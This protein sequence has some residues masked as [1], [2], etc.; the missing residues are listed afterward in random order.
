MRITGELFLQFIMDWQHEQREPWDEAFLAHE[1]TKVIMTKGVN[2]ASSSPSPGPSQPRPNPLLNTDNI[3]ERTVAEL[4]EVEILDAIE[5]EIAEEPDDSGDEDYQ[6]PQQPGKKK[7]LKGKGRAR[8]SDSEE[9]EEVFGPILDES[10][11]VVGAPTATITDESAEA[12]GAPTATIVD[13]SAEAVGATKKVA[14]VDYMTDADAMMESYWGTVDDEVEEPHELE[15]D[16]DDVD[17]I[18]VSSLPDTLPWGSQEPQGV[19]EAVSPKA[20]TPVQQQTSV[21]AQSSTAQQ[22]ST[23]LTKKAAKRQRQRERRKAKGKVQD[24]KKGSPS[25]QH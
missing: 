19:S 4:V 17:M 16:T 7:D 14:A 21:P 2:S 3:P 12:V 9:S 18:E 15:E 8:S 13:K 25:S 10:T 6:E 20:T 24:G 1:F 5:G 22:A 23:P 11:E